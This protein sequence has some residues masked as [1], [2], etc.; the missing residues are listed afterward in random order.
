MDLSIVFCNTHFRNPLVLASGI[1][2]VT[3]DSLKYGAESGA[4]GVTCKSVWLKEH[5]GHRNPTILATKHYVLNAVGL[6]SAGFE[7]VKEELLK[8]LRWSKTGE[9]TYKAPLIVSIVGAKA[10]DFTRIAKKIYELKPS[11]IE[12]N[13]SCPNL[14]DELSRPFAFDSK[15]SAEITR[16]V[17]EAVNHE[18]PVVVK[19]SPNTPEMVEVAKA[20][21]EAGADGIC[22]VNTVGPGMAIDLETR[23]PILANKIGGVSGPAI[24][25]IAVR[26]VYQIFEAVKIPIIGTGGVTTGEDAIEMMMA[27]AALVGIGSAVYYRGAE[28][29][30]KIEQ[31]MKKWCRENKVE[32]ISE[33]VG[34]A[35][36]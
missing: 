12:V 26:C 20:C 3:G 17:K 27:G 28:V 24:K 8:F 14:A 4:G 32:D 10:D 34:A 11:I 9:G 19:L 22:A 6:S 16:K 33:I 35:H 2:G 25:P 21:E 5:K 31:E 23:R 15:K 13:I 30:K 29:F 7:E 1:M 36:L 18:I